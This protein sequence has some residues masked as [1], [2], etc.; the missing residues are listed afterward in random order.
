MTDPRE[1]SVPP[2]AKEIAAKGSAMSMVIAQIAEAVAAAGAVWVSDY[3]ACL[4]RNRRRERTHLQYAA[5]ITFVA[6]M[7]LV[8][9]PVRAPTDG[10][11][12]RAELAMCVGHARAAQ[13]E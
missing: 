8:N 5:G 12:F 9:V 3:L 1:T 6:A 4:I 11:N 7:I 10:V 2:K 13:G